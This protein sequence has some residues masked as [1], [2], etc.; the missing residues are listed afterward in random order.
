MSEPELSPKMRNYAIAFGF[1]IAKVILIAESETHEEAVREA[2]A[3]LRKILETDA[4]L[5]DELRA[6]AVGVLL[7][8]RG[9]R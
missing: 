8:Q 5:T 4:P 6:R 1:L 7:D 2:R 3:G 9:T